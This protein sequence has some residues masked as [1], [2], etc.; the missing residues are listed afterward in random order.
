MTLHGACGLQQ[1]MQQQITNWKQLCEWAKSSA[2]PAAPV[3]LIISASAP[4]ANDLA[5]LLPDIN[6]VDLSIAFS[7]NST[8]STQ[9]GLLLVCPIAEFQLISIFKCHAWQGDS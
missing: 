8:H 7:S 4:R 3:V 5:K 9:T 1:H 2:G 6:K